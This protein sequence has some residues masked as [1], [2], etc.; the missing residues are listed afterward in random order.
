MA[1]PTPFQSLT[2]G[3]RGRATP[4]PWPKPPGHA[5]LELEAS[6]L[7]SVVQDVVGVGDAAEDGLV[8]GLQLRWAVQAEFP[9]MVSWRAGFVGSSASTLVITA[10]ISFPT[11]AAIVPLLD[12]LP[13]RGSRFLHS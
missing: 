13:E 12:W 10:R 9:K 3:S 5:A 8:I 6:L 4:E 2:I 11:R 7:D 1:H